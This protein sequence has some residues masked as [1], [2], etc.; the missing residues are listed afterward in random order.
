MPGRGGGN[1]LRQRSADGEKLTSRPGTR[2]VSFDER[3]KIAAPLAL[4][5]LLGAARDGP[6]RDPDRIEIVK[7]AE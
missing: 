6:D 3:Q 7:R 1:V 5:F 4:G 2:F